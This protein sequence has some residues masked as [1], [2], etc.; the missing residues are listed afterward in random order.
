[1]KAAHKPWP[2]IVHAAQAQVKKPA[3]HTLTYLYNLRS[4]L[5]THP[6]RGLEGQ[7]QYRPWMMLFLIFHRIHAGD[8]EPNHSETDNGEAMI[9]S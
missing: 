3:C 7:E 4:T 8:T 6:E 2:E 5:Y 9:N 1:M